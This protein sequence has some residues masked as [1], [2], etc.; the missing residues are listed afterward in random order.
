MDLSIEKNW[1][2]GGNSDNRNAMEERRAGQSEGIGWLF[3]ML[4][5]RWSDFY[6]YFSPRKGHTSVGE[7]QWELVACFQGRGGLPL[8]VS[9]GHERILLQGGRRRHMVET[10]R[11]GYCSQEVKC[12]RRPRGDLYL[13]IRGKTTTRRIKGYYNGWFINSRSQRPLASKRERKR[14][15]KVADLL[16]MKEGPRLRIAL[17]S[18]AVQMRR[19]D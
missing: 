15:W 5:W 12:V 19:W 1:G 3:K 11:G 9:E 13:L 8:F 14:L 17:T 7:V 6:R 16:E 18:S 10:C 2:P 4:L